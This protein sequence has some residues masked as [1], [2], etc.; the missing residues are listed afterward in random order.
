MS[1]PLPISSEKTIDRTPYMFV[2]PNSLP[3]L[4]IQDSKGVS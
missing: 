2:S 1:N 3:K 4:P